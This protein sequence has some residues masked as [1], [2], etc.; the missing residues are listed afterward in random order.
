[1]I[2]S[3]RRSPIAVQHA[4]TAIKLI[5]QD[6]RELVLPEAF[7]AKQLDF[8]RKLLAR[9]Q[10]GLSEKPA[11]V[12]SAGPPSPREQDVPKADRSALE[13]AVTLLPH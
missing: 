8:A 6:V 10:A 1:M 4:E 13:E 2:L 12:E 3:T 9:A 11:S 7:P 5:D